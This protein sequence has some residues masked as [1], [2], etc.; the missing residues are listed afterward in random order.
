MKETKNYFDIYKDVESIL[1]VNNYKGSNPFLSIVIPT[2]S[3]VDLLKQLLDVLRMNKTDEEYEIVIVDNSAVLDDNVNEKL[4]K[5]YEDLPINYY[6]NK[7]NIGMEGNWN[8][9]IELA[10]AEFISMIHDDDLVSDIYLEDAKKIINKIKKK[11]KVGLIKV[12]FKTFN[13]ENIPVFVHTDSG[14]KKLIPSSLSKNLFDGYSV[15]CGPTCGYIMRKS[16]IIDT[17]GFSIDYHPSADNEYGFRL[18]SLGYKAYIT[19][20]ED[21][22]Y[23]I[24]RNETLKIDTIKSFIKCSDNI[25][26]N[27]YKYTLLGSLVSKLFARFLYSK[28]IDSTIVSSKNSFSTKVS[29]DEL[30]YNK[31]YKSYNAF[32]K[33]IF[34][35][36]SYFFKAISRRKNI[37]IG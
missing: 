13:E 24:L 8:R 5:E 29:I 9:G 26:S 12:S 18:L 15:L 19:S 33:I 36:V 22:Y 20:W 1:R 28:S 6:I 27:T 3:R 7:K 17:G 11:K 2:L 14:K 21:G 30:D 35:F 10:K 25:V 31:R 32:Q 4:I 37:F 16:M 34:K 23:R